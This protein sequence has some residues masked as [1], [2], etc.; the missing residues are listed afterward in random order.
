MLER[1]N[2]AMEH[3]ERHLDQPVEVAELARIA[4]TSEYHFRRLFSALAGIPAVEY[5][6]RRLTSPAG[7]CWRARSGCL[8]SRSAGGAN[9]CRLSR[10]WYVLVTLKELLA[11]PGAAS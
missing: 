9:C 6:R 8:T 11:V 4:V 2:Q 7:R 1:L 10:R 3:I 5:V